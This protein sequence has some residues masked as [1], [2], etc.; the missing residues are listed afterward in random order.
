MNREQFL[1][2]L[3]YQLR[4]LPKAERQEAMEFY[5]NYLED[6]GPEQE[7]EVLRSL[8]SPRAV[9]AEIVQ[10]AAVKAVEKE[11]PVNQKKR[12]ALTT[13]WMVVL[14]LC[15]APIALPLAACAVALMICL[16]ATAF[17]LLVAIF[18]VLLASGVSGVVFLWYG[19]PLLFTA[20]PSGLVV[21]G[22]G[23][24]LTGIGLI[25]L[26]GLTECGEASVKGI[27]RLFGRLIQRTKG[28][29]AA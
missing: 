6:A 28:G 1:K 2:E 15:A 27:A 10:A 8:G 12:G 20:L 24:V 7:A 9:A 3:E 17:C 26:V 13:V 21:A 19:V 4:R 16:L 29:K 23:L 11:Q 14:G 22:F 5:Q 25:V 18:L